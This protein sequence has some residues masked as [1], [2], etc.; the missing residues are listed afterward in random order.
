MS[1]ATGLY[2]VCFSNKDT[3][4]AEKVVA[5]SLHTGDE[6]FQD[7][8][9]QEHITPL[10]TEITQLTDGVA[11]IEDEQ[12]YMWARERQTAET[13]ASTNARVLWFSVAETV[14]IVGLGVWQ[15]LTCGR[16][17]ARARARGAPP[18]PRLSPPPSPR[19]SL[20]AF[21]QRKRKI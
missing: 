5:L 15:I 17:R 3:S 4:F 10:E 7:I 21:F 12:Q 11:K 19:R 6:L 14:V 2:E 8:A 18:C 1:P 13:N 16:A 9:R 20:R